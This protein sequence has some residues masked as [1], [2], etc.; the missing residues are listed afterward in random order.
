MTSVSETNKALG[1][2]INKEIWNEQRFDLIPE[3]FTEDFVADHSPLV[4]REGRDQIRTMVESA[5]SV[6]E[7]FSETVHRVIADDE[8]I[9]LYFTITGTQVADWGPIAATNRPVKYDEIVIM[10]VRD[11]KVCHQVVVSNRLLALQQLGSIPAPAG[12]VEKSLQ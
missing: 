6:F 11:G 12:F 4:I 7:G 5:H 9:V 10:K 3:C 8:N 1:L 2:R